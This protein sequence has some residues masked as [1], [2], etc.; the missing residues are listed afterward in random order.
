MTT[1]SITPNDRRVPLLTPGQIRAAVGEE[2]KVALE[3][4]AARNYRSV[5][6][7]LRMAIDGH[8]QASG[9]TKAATRS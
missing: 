1:I 6:A 5:S 2:R 8:L 9:G 7:E 4:L 3:E